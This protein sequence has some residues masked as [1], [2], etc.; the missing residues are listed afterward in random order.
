MTGRNL[1]MKSNLFMQ[2]LYWGPAQ[3][4]EI[5]HRQGSRESD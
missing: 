1:K 3:R 2:G 4:E 5:E